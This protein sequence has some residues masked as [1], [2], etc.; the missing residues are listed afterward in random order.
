MQRGSSLEFG[1]RFEELRS[2]I[3]VKEAAEGDET[4]YP[5]EEW[6][7]STEW[8]DLPEESVEVSSNLQL[9][10]RE[11]GE[12]EIG[13]SGKARRVW[14]MDDSV[15]AREKVTMWESHSEMT[16]AAGSQ[17]VL[18][19]CTVANWK[20]ALSMSCFGATSMVVKS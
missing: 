12:V 19:G 3:D 9:T 18:V 6:V 14:L 2:V 13:P 20:G 15:G 8:P 5:V 4:E 16:C 1:G 17:V 11:L 7:V 10:V